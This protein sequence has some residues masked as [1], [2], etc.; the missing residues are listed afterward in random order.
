MPKPEKAETMNNH[1]LSIAITDALRSGTELPV[2]LKALLAGTL[3]CER[4]GAPTRL[5]MSKIGG[6]SRGSSLNHYADL[7]AAIVEL[8]PRALMEMTSDQT[9]PVH[10]AALREDLHKR[11]ETIQQLRVELA[12]QKRS[13]ED[14]RRYAL[15]VHERLRDVNAQVAAETGAKVSTLFPLP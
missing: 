6:F 9:D 12:A 14:L 1:S 8:L 13:Q 10:A 15:A 2:P 7:L 11:D 5:G 4:G 3:I